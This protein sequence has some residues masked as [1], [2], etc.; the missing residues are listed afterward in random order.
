MKL[1]RSVFENYEKWEKKGYRLPEF[2]R[3]AMICKT[4]QNPT[5][6]HFGAGNIF[7]AF[8]ANLAQRMLD[9]KEM[10]CGIVV[11]EGY[12]YE[13]IKKMYRPHD[14]LAILVTLKGN[15]NVEKKVVGSVA[16]SLALAPGTK[17][18]K[19]LE[20]IFAMKSLQL[21]TFTITEKGY[22]T[23]DSD[24]HIL[25]SIAA[26]IKAGPACAVSYLG[27]VVSLLYHR[28]MNG[29]YPIA[30]V[31]TDNCSRNG[32]KFLEAVKIIA[33]G[34]VIY[35]KVGKG[36]LKY[37][38]DPSKVAFPWCMIDKITPRPDGSVEKMLKEDGI[39]NLEAV[40][41]EKLSYVAPFVNAEECEYLVIEDAFPNG[42]PM[43]EKAGVLF[44]DRETV[45]KVERM[46]V[47]TCL[48]PLH[49]ALAVFGCLLGYTRISDEMKDPLLKKMVERIGYEEGF[50][51]VTDPGV[52]DPGE[53]LDTVLRERIPNPFIPD[54]PQR[55]ATDTSQ[56]LAIRFGE[57]IRNYQKAGLKPDSLQM[58][59][60]VFAGWIRYLM[61]LNDE[62]EPF[63]L[64]PDPMRE[65]LL[66][67]LLDLHLGVSREQ[68]PERIRPILR[69]A[70]IFGVDLS[71]VG[72]EEKVCE[73]FA[74]MI[75][76]TGAVRKTLQKYV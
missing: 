7:R 50:P 8:H 13:I 28:Y 62:G 27:K 33:E 24:G 57:T 3:D 70:N 1:D 39:R 9:A 67:I 14:N 30:M 52:L 37:V 63:V 43:L 35:E 73:Y 17:D 20:T 69:K 32:E 6:V 53:F 48:N 12:D 16:E 21:A 61:A 47:C 49:T 29:A 34:W 44:T 5:W 11:A 10:D 58:I 22:A 23:A 40:V 76:G 18:F 68:I 42:R 45:E 41:T 25:P 66:P 59:P 26:D 19:R 71:E 31:S 74:E 36:F 15:G 72:L 2:D 54:T 38:C 60:L 65:E 46:K 51:V 4:K 56:K 75:E 55:I 64:S